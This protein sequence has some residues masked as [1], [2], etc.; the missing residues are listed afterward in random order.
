MTVT[1][2]KTTVR[3]HPDLTP[4]A[5][6]RNGRLTLFHCT[7]FTHWLEKARDGVRVGRGRVKTYFGVGFYATAH[8]FQAAGRAQQLA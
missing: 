7:V 8:R 3:A 6:W 5:P 4:P 1:S 2:T